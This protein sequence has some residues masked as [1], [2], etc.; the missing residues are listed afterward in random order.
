MD[1]PLLQ[2][3]NRN[4]I[5]HCVSLKQHFN[6]TIH[7]WVICALW[8]F[9]IIQHPVPMELWGILPLKAQSLLPSCCYLNTLGNDVCFQMWIKQNQWRQRLCRQ[10]VLP[11]F[12]KDITALINVLSLHILAHYLRLESTWQHQNGCILRLYKLLYTHIFAQHQKHW[13][14]V[15]PMYT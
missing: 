9:S 3:R 6:Y 15:F 14:A 13:S 4:K 11:S 8:L 10:R 7:V 2:I 12:A 1:L 5:N